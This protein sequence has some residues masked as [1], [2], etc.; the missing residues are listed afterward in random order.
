MYWLLENNCP[1]PQRASVCVADVE[2][3]N[4]LLKLGIPHIDFLP[5]RIMGPM[6]VYGHIFED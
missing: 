6:P 5:R 3:Q 2:M 4:L 1:I